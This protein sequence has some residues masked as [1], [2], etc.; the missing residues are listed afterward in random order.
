MELSIIQM[1]IQMLHQVANQNRT[2]SFQSSCDSCYITYILWLALH[3]CT[4]ILWLALH[5]CTYILWLALHYCTYILWLALHYCTYILWLALHYCTYIL[6]PRYIT[7]PTFCDRVTFVTRVTMFKTLW[8]GVK[9]PD[10][11]NIVTILSSTIRWR[12]ITTFNASFQ[13]FIYIWRKIHI[14]V[15]RVTLPYQLMFE[16]IPWENKLDNMFFL[17]QHS[18]QRYQW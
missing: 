16:I 13:G 18:I 8:F 15:T 5:Y 3:Y 14:S 17:L 9:R 1:L 6:W 11:C 7:V 4:Y 12:R 10:M 2:F